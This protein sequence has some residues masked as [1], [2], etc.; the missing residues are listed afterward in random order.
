MGWLQISLRNTG[1]IIVSAGASHGNSK[2]VH[3]NGNVIKEASVDTV[4]DE[5]VSGTV[6]L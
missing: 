4:D 6:D 1:T 3:P 2:I 5:I